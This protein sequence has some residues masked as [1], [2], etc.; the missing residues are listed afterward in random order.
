MGPKASALALPGMASSAQS[1]STHERCSI[2]RGPASP[3][4]GWAETRGRAYIWSKEAGSGALMEAFWR[5]RQYPSKAPPRITL[6]V[7]LFIL[8]PK[9]GLRG[10]LNTLAVIMAPAEALKTNNPAVENTAAVLPS[11][12][13]SKA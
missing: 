2:D 8:P 1:R 7:T 13:Q 10:A 5:G 4:A 11:P 9:K 12:V 6:I 3:R